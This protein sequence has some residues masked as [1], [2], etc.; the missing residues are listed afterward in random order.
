MCKRCGQIASVKL[1]SQSLMIHNHNPQQTPQ[2]YS[3]QS[4]LASPTAVPR[5]TSI[6]ILIRTLLRAHAYHVT[7]LSTTK[8]HFI[9]SEIECNHDQQQQQQRGHSPQLNNAPRSNNANASW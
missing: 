5:F 1:S 2:H 7:L 3:T 4:H 9:G 6:V 8:K